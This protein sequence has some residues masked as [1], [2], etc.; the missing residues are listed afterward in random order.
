MKYSMLFRLGT[1]FI[2][3]GCGLLVLF[4]GSIFAREF[5]IL[6]LIF[7]AAALFLGLLFHRAAPRTEPTRFSSI[8]KANQRSRQRRE[9]KQSEKDQNK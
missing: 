5:N 3:I 1:F 6:Y 4:T 8:R 7:T 2:L 9:E